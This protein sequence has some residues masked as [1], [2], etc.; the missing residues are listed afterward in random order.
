MTKAIIWMLCFGAGFAGSRFL[1]AELAA[2]N[3]R[4]SDAK[5]MKADSE[6]LS[7]EARKEES[8]EETLAVA[9]AMSPGPERRTLLGKALNAY[10]ET[11]PNKLLILVEETGVW[12][13][14]TRINSKGHRYKN[15]ALVMPSKSPG[16]IGAWNTGVSI[17]DTYGSRIRD[18]VAEV[19]KGSPRAALRWLAKV[20]VPHEHP[21]FQELLT[22]TLDLWA[23]EEQSAVDA[24][25]K[26]FGI[27]LEEAAE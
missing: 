9:S 21:L 24:W 17:G 8:P 10:P 20:D 25:K 6:W 7:R 2:M 15:E 22:E 12:D 11:D 5:S 16:T 1:G 14:D 27:D 18:S 4:L 13:L 26:R 19:A 3:E 23:E